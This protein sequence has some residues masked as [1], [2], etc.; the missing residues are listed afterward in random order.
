MR[1]QNSKARSGVNR[2][3]LIVVSTWCPA[4]LADMQRVR[5][6]GGCLQS[7]GWEVEILAPDATFQPD[8][9]IEPSAGRF[10]P[11]CKVH[12]VG[13]WY[14]GLFRVLRAGTI[15]W[16]ASVPVGRK[17]DELLAA[18]GF[19]LVYFSTTVHLLTCWGARWRRKHGVPYVADVHDPLCKTGRRY[20]T[21]K[22][23]FKAWVAERVSWIIERRA[24]GCADGLVSVSEGYLG[25]LS[26]R[27]PRARWMRAGRH[28]VQPFPADLPGLESTSAAGG[29]PGRKRIVYVGA[30]GTIMERGWRALLEVWKVGARPELGIELHG[31]GGTLLPGQ[32]GHL[33]GIAE[34]CGVAAVGERPA[35]ISYAR[36]L[37][38]VKGADGLLVLGVDDPNYRPSKLHG[39]LA[40]GLPVLVVAHEH[41]GLVQWL[42]RAGP[43]VQIVRFG[44]SSHAESNRLAVDRFVADVSSSR[45]WNQV[46]RVVL[47]PAVAAQEHAVFF[48]GVMEAS[49]GHT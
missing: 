46:D 23:R 43:G 10:F 5:L 2:R 8:Y 37:D 20:V 33:Q 17:G 1:S 9:S 36:S 35:R 14:P 34:E 38:L 29:N 30:G 32:K 44:D 41:S 13:A 7:C 6:I 47:S 39:Y 31:T 15:G 48:G 12:F 3:V 21:T 11:Q 16:R 18:G 19:D 45:R 22:G 42:R 4:M 28:L 49:M 27:Y 26:D 25:D 40:T 24:L